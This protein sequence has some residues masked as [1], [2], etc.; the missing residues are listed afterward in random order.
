MFVPDWPPSPRLHV[1]FHEAPVLEF[2]QILRGQIADIRH[3]VAVS[4][5]FTKIGSQEFHAVRSHDGH[6]M[7]L[8]SWI[9]NRYRK[10][11]LFNVALL[12]HPVY[13]RLNRLPGFAWKPD[14]QG[15]HSLHTILGADP[16]RSGIVVNRYALL[17]GLAHL[18]VYRL[19]PERKPDQAALGQPCDYRLS[20]RVGARARLEDRK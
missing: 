20:H 12:T 10:I 13:S 15:I 17:H 11:R 6:L 1:Y 4:E 18:R 9:G 14:H 2:D 7:E 8:R 3:G 5:I 19:E 16:V